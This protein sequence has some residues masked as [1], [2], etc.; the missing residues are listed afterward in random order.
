M[1]F[2]S[3]E[4][5]C[6]LCILWGLVMVTPYL[7]YKSVEAADNYCHQRHARLT[8]RGIEVIGLIYLA[9]FTVYAYAYTVKFL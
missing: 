5:M 7:F 6:W 2:V 3:V 9:V 8:D 1:R 4:E